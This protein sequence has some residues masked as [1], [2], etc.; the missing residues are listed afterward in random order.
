MYWYQSAY[1]DKN[2][3]PNIECISKTQTVQGWVV[4]STVFSKCPTN[5]KVCTSSTT[6]DVCESPTS[7]I[8]DLKVYKKNSPHECIQCL[9]EDSRFVNADGFCEDCNIVDCQE[10]DHSGCTKCKDG[11]NFLEGTKDCV[12]CNAVE[13]RFVDSDGVCKV[14]LENCKTCLNKME[15]QECKSGLNVLKGTS[16]PQECV[17]C[18]SKHAHFVNSLNNLCGPCLT[19]CDRCSKAGECLECKVG[20]KVE[21]GSANPQECKQCPREGHF[22]SQND[23]KCY[24]CPTNCQSCSSTMTCSTCLPNY[25]IK[26]DSQNPQE[27]IT[28]PRPSYYIDPSNPKVCEACIPNC[29]SCQSKTEC[30]SCSA[31]FYPVKGA[32]PHECSKCDQE[33]EILEGGECLRCPEGCAD[34]D[35]SSFCKRC[36]E[37]KILLVGSN[38]NICISKCPIDEG[39]FVWIQEGRTV[40]DLCLEGCALCES[41]SRCYWCSAK[42]S[43]LQPNGIHCLGTCPKDYYKDKKFNQCKNCPS[44]CKTT[45]H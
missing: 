8:L 7:P 17:D 35:D 9:K 12:Q 32:S 38:P 26:S 28:C 1:P 27:C 3:K 40:C 5:C 24:P 14:C 39:R 31:G 37:G 4:G 45:D 6:C 22:V 19:D 25:K 42:D 23:N 44:G 34:C 2:G 21:A 15:C 10:C 43:F 20:F 41:K 11:F 36:S 33:G 30:L 29:E 18:S 13:G 16:N